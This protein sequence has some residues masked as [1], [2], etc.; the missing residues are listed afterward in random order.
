L[1]GRARIFDVNSRVLAIAVAALAVAIAA[2]FFVTRRAETPTSTPAAEVASPAPPP[3]EAPAPAP[4]PAAPS[5]SERPRAARPAAAPEASA[6]PAAGVEVVPDSGTLRIETDVPNAQ[7]FLDRQFIGTAPVT[8]A[9]VKPGTHQL[10]VSAEGFE[11]VARSIEVEAGSKDLMIRFREV[12]LDARIGVVHKHRMGSC[13]GELV[14]TTQ[15]L[16]YTTDDKDDRFSVAFADVEQFQVDYTEK[17]LKVKVRR[18]KQYNFTDPDGNADRLFVF[19]RD[20]DKARQRLA[21]GDRP[22]SN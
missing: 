1:A 9:N 12:K 16:Q 21:S 6:A 8:A 5:P 13:K 19:H 4:E 7:V 18:G 3:A 2:F 15:G 17:N 11:G 22:A 10:N 14:A 20:V